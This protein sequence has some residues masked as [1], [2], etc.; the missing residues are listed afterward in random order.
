MVK[1]YSFILWLWNFVMQRPPATSILGFDLFGTSQFFL[2][3]SGIFSSVLLLHSC[4]MS[5]EESDQKIASREL[6]KNWEDSVPWLISRRVKS[7]FFM[8]WLSLFKKSEDYFLGRSSKMSDPSAPVF[9]WRTWKITELL[10]LNRW[11]FLSLG[12][13][14]INFWPFHPLQV[15]PH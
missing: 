10:K 14:D 1:N 9:P 15:V 12:S 7:L 5:N 2:C 4:G 6:C 13:K 8:L 3:I 11:R